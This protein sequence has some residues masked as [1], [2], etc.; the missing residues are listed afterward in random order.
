MTPLKQISRKSL[1]VLKK[2]KDIISNAW[3]LCNKPNSS[4]DK[5]TSL[6]V[7]RIGKAENLER[8]IMSKRNKLWIKLAFN[9][10]MMLKIWNGISYR[11]WISVWAIWRNFPLKTTALDKVLSIIL[12]S[13]LLLPTS[14]Q[15]LEQRT[16]WI[17]FGNSKK[18]SSMVLSN[19]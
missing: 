12:G 10:S 3:N 17:P 2:S 5:R 18:T 13:H 4:H 1:C 9:F 14:K 16:S 7:S 15:L 8:I 6:K 19:L 11:K